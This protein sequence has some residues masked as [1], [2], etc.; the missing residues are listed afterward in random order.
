MRARRAPAAGTVAVVVGAT[1]IV[2]WIVAAFAPIGYNPTDDGFIIGQSARL[3][4]GDI[5]HVDLIS[6]RPLGSGYLHVFDLLLPLPLMDATRLVFVAQMAVTAVLFG[7]VVLRRPPWQWHVVEAAGAV[8]S[9]VGNIHAFPLMPWHTTDGMLVSSAG[10]ALAGP[11]IERGSVRL[12]VPAFALLG[13]APVTKQSFLGV[14]ALGLVW[15]AWAHRRRATSWEGLRPVLIAA[16]SAATPLVVYGAIVAAGGGLDD[17]VRQLTNSARFTETPV[18][19]ALKADPWRRQVILASAVIFAAMAGIRGL[20]RAGGK[21]AQIASCG[22]RLGASATVL[23]VLVHLDL[24]IAAQ[25]GGQLLVVL[26]VYLVGRLVLWGE[27]DGRATLIFAMAAMVTVSWGY[28]NPDLLG[29]TIAF[30]VIARLLTLGSVPS[31]PAWRMAILGP[32]V[33]VGIVVVLAT[34]AHARRRDVYFDRAETELS[35]SLRAIDPDFGRVRSTAST[36][37]YLGDIAA[38][39]DRHPAEHVAVLP[40]NPGLYP[41][42]ELDSPFP[43]E[44]FYPP[45]YVGSEDRV[46]EEVETVAA[47]GSYLVMFQTFS[48]FALKDHVILP[49]A[50]PESAVFTHGDGTLAAIARILAESSERVVCGSLVAFYDPS[51]DR[52]G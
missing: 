27:F 51:E 41:I 28:A 31:L 8:A 48:A 39:V 23:A 34:F 50:G 3:L 1:A 35:A 14:P 49:Q 11:A 7:I 29:G 47:R 44:W 36:A 37:Q 42:L 22:V 15:I 18:V 46:I 4:A 13:F 6:P 24:A 12:L 5:P 32:A 38:C 17:L 52:S 40:D 45:E 30:V 25:W 43:L 33:V 20:E 10:L 26:G 16:A 2:A 19:A 21:R 9:V